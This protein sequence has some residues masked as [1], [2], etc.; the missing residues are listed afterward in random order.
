MILMDSCMAQKS[1]NEV[2][3]I[4]WCQRP[5]KSGGNDQELRKT[6]SGI[7]GARQRR[8][9]PSSMCGKQPMGTK[10]RRTVKVR[11]PKT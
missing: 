8:E 6:G 10:D 9:R 3:A 5:G 1:R 2:A 4:P 11:E 7:Y